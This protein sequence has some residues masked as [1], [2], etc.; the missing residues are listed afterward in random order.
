M[1]SSEVGVDN[2]GELLDRSGLL[3]DAFRGNF[4]ETESIKTVTEPIQKGDLVVDGRR[5]YSQG[6]TS[7]YPYQ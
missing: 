6:L 2:K 7:I 3:L 4:A 1:Y 5:Y